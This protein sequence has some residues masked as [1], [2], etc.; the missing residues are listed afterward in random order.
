MEKHEIQSQPRILSG[1]K[2][3]Q[4]RS[5]GL[6]PGNVFG[7]KIKSVNIQFETK[8]FLKI[9]SKIG[10]STLAYL[11]IGGEKEDRPVFITDTV[12]DPAG[13]QLLHVTFHQVDLKEKV[14]A[15]VPIKMIGESLAEKEKLGILVQQLDELEVEALPA[16]MPEH[17]EV[18]VSG[19]A[20]VG[21]H[22]MVSDLKLDI[23]KL[24]VKT[25]PGIIVVQIEALAKEEVAPPA[26]E[27]VVEG[28]VPVEGAPEVEGEVPAPTAEK[29]E[30]KPKPEK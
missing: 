7:K 12:K 10:E 26:P 14:I 13:G 23:S 17:I 25:D 6:T 3:K 22:I 19:L 4:L 1:R 28:E 30:V 11:R 16:D 21:T 24:T 2:V 15:P 27:A 18:D 8:P 20:E 5:K 29:P 9:F